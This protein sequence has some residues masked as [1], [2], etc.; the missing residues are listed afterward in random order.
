MDIN[1]NAPVVARD[2]IMIRADVRD[3]W[4]LLTDFAGW[5]KWLPEVPRAEAEGLLGVGA[6]FQW[7]TKGLQI[8]STVR[9]IDPP[10]RIA[11]DGPGSGIFG[12]HV[13][14][15]EP[16]EGGVL[17]RTRESWEGPPVEGNRAAMQGALAGSLRGHLE[18][19]KIA[20]ERR[21]DAPPSPEP[22]H[23]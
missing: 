23:P 13:W 15:F 8:S 22:Q 1:F 17:V 4:R 11:W 10:Y 20:A 16:I 19:L 7:E 3:V 2:E 9:E 12:V 18:H 5:P 14:M 21:Q 6:A